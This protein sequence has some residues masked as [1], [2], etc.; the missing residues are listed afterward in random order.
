MVLLS[1]ILELYEKHSQF[2][3]FQV[4]KMELSYKKGSD[5]GALQVHSSEDASVLLL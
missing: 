3:P 4:V 1:F 5:L 2:I